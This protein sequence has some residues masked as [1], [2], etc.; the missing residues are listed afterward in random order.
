MA[1]PVSSPRP[2]IQAKAVD[3]HGSVRE[4]AAFMEQ[5]Q[6]LTYVPG[7]SNVRRQIDSDVRKG[8]QPSQLLNYRLHWVTNQKASGKPDMTKVT[9]FRAKGYQFMKFDA[10]L[11]GIE[12]PLASFRSP[13]GY[14]QNG[15]AVLMYCD[16][17]TASRLE[18]DGRSAIDDT[19]TDEYTSQHLHAEG[20]SAAR[21]L[22]GGSN[23]L[24][25]SKT[26]HTVEVSPRG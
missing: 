17:A 11:D 24:T 16:A 14:I 7:Y 26:E 20:R 1:Q 25:T 23:D 9:Q 21:E 6:D 18:Q 15:D 4:Q 2:L 5:G 19:S 12:V 3:P 10:P 13:D 22:G 8:R